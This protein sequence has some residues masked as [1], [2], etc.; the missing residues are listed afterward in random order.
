MCRQSLELVGR[1]HKWQPGDLGDLGSHLLGKTD[2]RVES[3]ADGGTASGQ[4]VKAGE[5]RLDAVNAW[6]KSQT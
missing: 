1:G 5:G 6:K 3:G 2:P 4:H